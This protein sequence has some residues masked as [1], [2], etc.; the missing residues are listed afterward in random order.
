MS[1]ASKELPVRV[2]VRV[3]PLVASERQAGANTVIGTD[4]KSAQ[5]VLGKDRTFAFDFAY[6]IEST[7][8]GIYEDIVQ[9][10]EEKVLKGYNATL[11]A[12]GQTGSGKTYTMGTAHSENIDPDH[13]GVIPRVIGS[14]FE[15]IK[16]EERDE[17]AQ[18]QIR[19]SFL[20][21]HNEQINDLLLLSKR[22][23][24]ENM[25]EHSNRPAKN[26]SVCIRENSKG[27]IVLA[28]LF[29]E[30]VCSAEEIYSCLDRGTKVRQTA[31]TSMNNSSSRS[32]AIFTITLERQSLKEDD[33]AVGPTC[34]KF[35]LVDLAGSE[36]VKKTKAEGSRLREGI[37]INM[38]L[39]A[40]GNVISALGDPSKRSANIHIP[41]RD[42]K[43]TRILQ[44]SLGGNSY[45]AMI[46]CVSP[47]DSNMD[48]TVNTLR[49]A[50]RAR[51][52][53]NKPIVNS[54]P[55]SA[56]MSRLRQQLYQLQQ[57]LVNK[58]GGGSAPA[59]KESLSQKDAEINTL[60]NHVLSLEQER[61]GLKE[62]V[63][64]MTTRAREN[65]DELLAVSAERDRLRFARETGAG[66]F[67]NGDEQK[68]VL[69]EQAATIRK[70]TC[71]V[72]RLETEALV[73][74]S[75]LRNNSGTLDDFQANEIASLESPEFSAGGEGSDESEIMHKIK[76]AKNQHEAE[77]TTIEDRIEALNSN[78][79]QKENLITRITSN[80]S[81]EKV[82]KIRE[83]YEKNMKALS[84]EV[85]DLTHE[86]EKL[87]HDLE[88]AKSQGLEVKKVSKYKSRLRTLEKQLNNLRGKQVRQQK[89]L[90]MKSVSDAKVA[91]L[92]SEVETMKKQKIRLAS[93]KH[94]AN[95]R[96]RE[97]KLKREHELSALR[98]Q[99]R[100]KQIELQKLQI[101]HNRQKNV[102]KRK[103]EEAASVRARSDSQKLKRQNAEILRAQYA[104][105]SRVSR[106][107]LK[108]MIEVFLKDYCENQTLKQTLSLEVAARA[109][110]SKILEALQRSKKSKLSMCGP[111]K[112]EEIK[113]LQN[114][115]S[116]H[117]AKIASL[118]QELVEHSVEDSGMSKVWAHVR[119]VADAKQVIKQ[120]VATLE[121]AI[122]H[123]KEAKFNF[124]QMRSK[125]FDIKGKFGKVENE[126]EALAVN[127][128]KKLLEIQNDHE[129]HMALI[130]DQVS[131][132]A[133]KS[134]TGTAMTPVTKKQQSF[135]VEDTE[136]Y[137][138]E[139]FSECESTNDAASP[140]S[141]LLAMKSKEVAV[142]PD[143]LSR[144]AVSNNPQKKP[145]KS[146][147]AADFAILH[148]D[149]PLDVPS[150]P[151]T[152][153]VETMK[154]PSLDELKI[155]MKT[156]GKRRA[157]R[158]ANSKFKRR[159]ERSY[160]ELHEQKAAAKQVQ[161]LQEKLH[162]YK[163]MNKKASTG[164]NTQKR[165]S[166]YAGRY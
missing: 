72:E 8:E 20:E 156:T 143:P 85:Q 41:Y 58:N 137:A 73:T 140:Q 59:G 6:G 128:E 152:K 129:E 107:G 145:K 154:M 125:Y 121:D 144:A 17:V 132:P 80:M 26:Q 142:K 2:A 70:L 163:Q 42:S 54:D 67:E 9:P 131:V 47:A 5:A 23:N 69:E 126:K 15:K 28:G 113:Q 111:E 114:T 22:G 91:Q 138:Y 148:D 161:T 153:P 104:S 117:S 66:Y 116:I 7:Q 13:V 39:L 103:M 96:F 44:D 90:E 25:V 24:E 127:F 101:A 123:E 147:T 166:K 36:R 49:Y 77:N 33:V 133:S 55:A 40:L 82:E 94:K 120:A 46:A 65:S 100:M 18:Y 109:S 160:K 83:M 130:L 110:A 60:K 68:S 45:T 81:D 84:D 16:T 51:N 48:E 97:F 87:L 158:N 112:D 12:Y 165:T 149:L 105:A 164:Y 38:G 155:A 162:V 63:E 151:S 35:H 32:H 98:K 27:K 62:A 31:S 95:E 157:L 88:Q 61:N 50:H 146:L 108:S 19:V 78:L 53:K 71:K 124:S 21:I 122:K 102:L 92:K 37:N 57:Q 10:L 86:R 119:S 11:L 150:A 52:I 135:V 76:H 141:D 30:T 93:Q 118:N 43:L 64:Q 14:L 3:R 56:E 79:K 89:L 136:Y 134:T 99:N 75:L 106:E 139:S 4:K 159:A 1:S 29:E 115:I 74:G 34:G